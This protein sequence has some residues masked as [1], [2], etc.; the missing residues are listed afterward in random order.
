MKYTSRRSP[1]KKRLLSALVHLSNFL[2]R[3]FAQSF[4]ESKSRKGIPKR[5]VL[6]CG[7]LEIR[8]L[9]FC[10]M[11]N[12]FVFAS[13]LPRSLGWCRP[14]RRHLMACKLLLQYSTSFEPRD[15]SPNQ[16]QEPPVDITRLVLATTLFIR[17]TARRIFWGEVTTNRSGFKLADVGRLL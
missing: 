6:A 8:C 9:F 17:Q 16:N 13:T 2:T 7:N 15:V 3:H 12:H 1:K 11:E 14:V 5:V 4:P 10:V